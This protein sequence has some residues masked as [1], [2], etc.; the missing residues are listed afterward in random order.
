MSTD[1]GVPWP[2]YGPETRSSYATV[3]SRVTAVKNSI[4]SQSISMLS[5]CSSELDGTAPAVSQF[6]AA[7]L[8]ARGG[9]TLAIFCSQLA[10][11]LASG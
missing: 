4:P 10:L 3:P 5:R 2:A 9:T 6:A 7:I 1:G 8:V 11:S